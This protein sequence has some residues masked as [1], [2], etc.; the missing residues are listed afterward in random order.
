MFAFGA[1][2]DLAF[3]VEGS[4]HHIFSL[5]LFILNFLLEDGT[6]SIE[7]PIKIVTELQLV[8]L[9]LIISETK[10]N[11]VTRV[12]PKDILTH[13]NAKIEQMVVFVS[14]DMGD[15]E[16]TALLFA[17]IVVSNADPRY[18]ALFRTNQKTEGN[19]VHKFFIELLPG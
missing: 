10:L 13:V 17:A 15:N 5:V 8:F 18:L 1:N 12:L 11:L 3:Q 14:P 19:F 2:L 6:V 7:F 9:T 4:F 16:L